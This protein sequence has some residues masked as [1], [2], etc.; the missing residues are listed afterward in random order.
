MNH[1]HSHVEEIAHGRAIVHDAVPV[2]SIPT[3]HVSDDFQ[4]TAIRRPSAFALLNRPC[5]MLLALAL[6]RAAQRLNLSDH[7][8]IRSLTLVAIPIASQTS[9]G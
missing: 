2:S 9:V 4:R 1:L 6:V 3:T 5:A 7:Q 8:R